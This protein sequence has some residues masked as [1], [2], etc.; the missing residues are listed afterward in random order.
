MKMASIDNE[1][2]K[3]CRCYVL[4]TLHCGLVALEDFAMRISKLPSI[5]DLSLES[6]LIPYFLHLNAYTRKPQVLCACAFQSRTLRSS[7]P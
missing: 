5:C 3:Q 7:I 1:D 4:P 2:E 6:E